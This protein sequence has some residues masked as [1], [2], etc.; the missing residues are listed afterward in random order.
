MPAPWDAA[1]SAPV[2]IDFVGQIWGKL[3]GI[4]GKK[5][6]ILTRIIFL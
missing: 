2:G 1:V 5:R 6:V 3:D 4:Y